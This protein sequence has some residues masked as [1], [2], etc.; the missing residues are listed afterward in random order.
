MMENWGNGWERGLE[1]AAVI[2]AVDGTTAGKK[3]D[4]ACVG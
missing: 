1:E 2:T 3:C 4:F